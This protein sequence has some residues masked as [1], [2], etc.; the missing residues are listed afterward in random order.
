VSGTLLPTDLQLVRADGGAAP[1]VQ[2]VQWDAPSRTATFILAPGVPANG[3]YMATL[4]AYSVNSSAGQPL[5]AA[6]SFQYTFLMGDATRDGIV[7]TF[8]F[9]AL[10]TH[11]GMSGQS[12][13]TGDFNYDHVVNALDFNAMSTNFGVQLPAS[14]APSDLFSSLRITPEE[15]LAGVII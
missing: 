2:S 13:S 14:A 6:Y 10:A 3:I 1:A 8:D 11:F 12:W 7:N 4:P 15:D 5:N 9:D